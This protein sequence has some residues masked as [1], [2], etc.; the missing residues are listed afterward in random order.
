M[1]EEIER[2]QNEMTEWNLIL[3]RSKTCCASRLRNF[4]R[5][6]ARQRL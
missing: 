1:V 2:T 6:N 3:H 5:R 4:C